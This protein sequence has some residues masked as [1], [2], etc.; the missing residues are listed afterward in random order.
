MCGAGRLDSVGPYV[1]RGGCEVLGRWWW[2]CVPVEDE[3]VVAGEF[4]AGCDGESVWGD[5]AAEECA[6]VA[7][8]GHCGPRVCL[9]EGRSGGGA[10][11]T[12][13]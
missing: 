10:G 9:R 1:G 11:R 4:G 12:H 5:V 2:W 8:R 3:G 13:E 7:G 6:V